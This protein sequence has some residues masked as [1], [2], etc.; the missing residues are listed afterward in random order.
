MSIAAP[1]DQDGN[2]ALFL[3]SLP[4]SSSL[5]STCG[6]DDKATATAATALE[7]PAHLRSWV[8]DARPLSGTERRCNEHDKERRR[9]R[10]KSDEKEQDNANDSGS[11]SFSSSAALLKRK[12]SPK[13]SSALPST[14]ATASKRVENM[15]SMRGMPDYVGFGSVPMDQFNEAQ[16]E[17]E[18]EGGEDLDL[19][20]DEDKGDD[21][22]TAAAELV[23]DTAY[24]REV[25]ELL[26]WVWDSDASGTVPVGF[27]LK[28]DL[29]V[30]RALASSAFVDGGDEQE[31]DQQRKARAL[32]DPGAC[33]DIQQL[34]LVHSTARSVAGATSSNRIRTD[35]GR[36]SSRKQPPGLSSCVAH[37]LGG[38]LSKKEQRSD[39]S[40]RPLHPEQLSYAA[41]DA[42]VLL[43]LLPLLRKE[44]QT[45]PLQ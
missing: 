27:A 20:L 35:S 23:E 17:E 13:R 38:K 34:A 33:L 19:D 45:S 36:P 43:A 40:R 16:G 9:S 18:E 15:E 31:Q 4:P 24:R 12:R 10:G 29:K 14:A 42:A 28:G 25:A 21:P 3:S 37:F 44:P 30:L 11:S 6:A 26:Q 32:F 2:P 39:W 41:M 7:L 5:V 8:I 1:F 22:A